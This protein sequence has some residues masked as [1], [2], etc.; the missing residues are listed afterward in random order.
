MQLSKVQLSQN[1]LHK[2]SH[3]N[4]VVVSLQVCVYN[5]TVCVILMLLHFH[6]DVLVRFLG[7]EEW[8]CLHC[9]Q[10][11]HKQWGQFVV[12]ILILFSF[13]IFA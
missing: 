9:Y 6:T 2:Q 13:S 12:N 4:S 5:S 1:G 8:L 7:T 10:T 11:L 3:A